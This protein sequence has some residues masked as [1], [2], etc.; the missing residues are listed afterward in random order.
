MGQAARIGGKENSEAKAMAVKL[1]KYKIS[2]TTQYEGPV[3]AYQKVCAS[4]KTVRR[5]PNRTDMFRTAVP[6]ALYHCIFHRQY[7]ESLQTTDN[8]SARLCHLPHRD[9]K[10][11]KNVTKIEYG[12]ENEDKTVSKTYVTNTQ[13]VSASESDDTLI[14]KLYNLP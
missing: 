10:R 8:R 12:T 7:Q 13:H 2:N 14:N 1:L 5:I 9:E 11:N 4:S 3:T 6:T